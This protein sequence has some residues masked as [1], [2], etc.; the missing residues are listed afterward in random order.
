MPSKKAVLL[1]TSEP[2]LPARMPAEDLSEQRR[3]AVRFI[4]SYSASA[5][6]CAEYLEIL[7]LNAAEGL[8]IG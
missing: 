6:E 3:Q 5:V 8:A 1:G 4:A 7:G 2:I